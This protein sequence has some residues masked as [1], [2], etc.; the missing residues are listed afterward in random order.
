MS[1]RLAWVAG[2]I[3]A[4]IAVLFIYLHT[5]KSDDFESLIKTKLTG[6]VARATDSLYVLSIDNIQIDVLK[7]TVTANG[8]QLQVDSSRI[9]ILDERDM[10]PD[11]LLYTSRCV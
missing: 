4:I 5:R 10:L 11:C 2:G 1:R 3:I 6:M 8:V 9:K 7:S